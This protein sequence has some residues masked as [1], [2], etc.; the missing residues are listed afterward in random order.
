MSLPGGT[1]E[2]RG[3]GLNGEKSAVHLREGSRIGR[4]RETGDLDWFVCLFAF[5]CYFEIFLGDQKLLGR[6]F[7]LPPPRV[8]DGGRTRFSGAP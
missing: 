8:V 5:L 4:Y 2:A 6:N 7:L 3:K 1:R